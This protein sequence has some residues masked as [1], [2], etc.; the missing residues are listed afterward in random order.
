MPDMLGDKA[1]F[2]ISSGEDH[3]HVQSFTIYLHQVTSS[4]NRN[5]IKSQRV[6]RSRMHVMSFCSSFQYNQGI[7]CIR[8]ISG[9]S[10]C[11]KSDEKFYSQ[12]PR[13]QEYVATY[14]LSKI[15]LF[16]KCCYPAC[17]SGQIHPP[18]RRSPRMTSQKC[19]NDTCYSC[20]V[21]YHTGQSCENFARARLDAENE[22]LPQEKRSARTIRA[23]TNRCPG[24]NVPIERESGC[25]R[26]ACGEFESFGCT[27]SELTI[28][29]LV[30]CGKRFDWTHLRTAEKPKV[31]E[32]FSDVETE[33]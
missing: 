5:S 28:V 9:V 32:W 15:K 7:H 33:D 8:T 26:M 16:S 24:C 17:K 12:C 20:E 19:G 10:N 22:L 11:A 31:A 1:S 18:G 27:K 2:F 25:V 23:T 6:A 14:R 13:Y 4:R 3:T 29:S 21:P 30:A